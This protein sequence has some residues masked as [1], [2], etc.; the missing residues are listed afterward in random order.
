MPELPEVETA[1]NGISPYLKGFFIEKIIVRQP[2]LRW[3]VSPELA[4]IS[5][6][7][8]TALSR[9]AKY[10]IIHTETGFIIGHL[11][12]S[13]SVR[14]VTDKDPI[15]KHD[16]L[17]IVMNN[18]K[19]MRYNDPRRFGAWLWTDNLDEFH[20]FANLGP[21]PLSDEFNANYLFQKSRKKSTALK[22]FL[23]DNSVV[24]GVGNIYANEVLF[25]CE[26]HPEK[27]AG[28]ITKTQAILLTDTIKVELT[29]AI[30][31]GGTTL[32]D[33][34]QPDGKP[35]YFAQELQIYGKKGARCPKCG[36]KIESLVIGQRNSY[37]CPN[38]QK[39]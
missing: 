29:R 24:V 28:K 1:K 5:H 25:Y 39:K 7:K 33:F 11:G 38:C 14:I 12:M 15:E 26:L 18:G 36:H 4:Q 30:Q 22:S 8:V 19:I 23:M 6:Q 10:L 37:I 20:L 17:D 32:K 2:K 9:R 27:P 35:G 31:Q 34:L 13:G 16:H 3:E 21:E